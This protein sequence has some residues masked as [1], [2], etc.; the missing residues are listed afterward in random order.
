[1][2]PE[3]GTFNQPKTDAI[4]RTYTGA[5]I[6]F[7][8]HWDYPG[9]IW[10]EKKVAPDEW[11]FRFSC[12]KQRHKAA[13]QGSGAGTG[14]QYHWFIIADQRAVKTTTDDYK[15]IMVGKKWKMGHKRPYWKNFSYAYPEQ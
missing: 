8:H 15:T 4:G 13:P 1:M 2:Q 6:G 12:T 11:R 3:V 14:T 5:K 10:D 7:M 9:G